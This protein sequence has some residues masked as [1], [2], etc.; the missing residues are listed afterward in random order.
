MTPHL[1]WGKA[2]ERRRVEEAKMRFL[3][4]DGVIMDADIGELVEK[5]HVLVERSERRVYSEIFSR[6]DMAK[7][8]NSFYILHLLEADDES[9]PEYWIFRKWGR[10]GVNQG[11]TKVES[12]GNCKNKAIE[13]FK[14]MYLERTGNTFGHAKDDFEVQPGLFVRV[15]VEHKALGDPSKIVKGQVKELGGDQ[16]L[17]KLTK[18]QVEK[19]EMVLDK[20]DALL[21]AGED[22]GS[23]QLMAVSAEYYTL[24][25][26]DFGTKLPPPIN[27][28]E[29]F[30]TEKAL[31][32]FYLRMGFEELGGEED[33][34]PI[35]GVMKLPVP[36]TLGDAAKS[37][38][39]P[40]DIKSCDTKGRALHKKK[41]GS[42]EKPIGSEMY[43]SILLYT[44]NAIY[45]EL[46]KALRDEKRELVLK[47]YPYL[48]L[49]F[50]ACDRLPQRKKTLWRGVGV[51]LFPQY[52]V[53][54]FIIWWGVS[55]CTSDESV[56]R[57]FMAGCGDGATLLTVETE[58]A[59]DISELSFFA[60]EAESILLPGTK[61]EVLSAQ[62][63]GGKSEI[64]L[65]EVGR[66]VS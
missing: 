19:G 6:T 2:R 32:Q 40:S 66:V 24:I 3:E 8:G 63:K 56:A 60:N 26:H 20:I 39:K 7:G 48:R 64:K 5:A 4:K 13:Q 28:A 27:S 9:E 35:D 30:G 21:Q 1:L 49:L 59:T 33:L 51:D 11:G 10:I 15:D 25:P 34:T 14:K 37:V 47:Y 18:K 65:R 50:E 38:C 43:G 16:P 36:K 58:T 23:A 29:L 42:P 41:A 62:R 31:V 44:S 55:S 12:F 53:G 45:R 46:N 61:L 52:K 57:N 22:P 17:G 54:T